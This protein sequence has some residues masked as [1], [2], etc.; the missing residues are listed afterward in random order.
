MKLLKKLIVF[1]AAVGLAGWLITPT[2]SGQNVEPSG[3]LTGFT[4]DGSSVLVTI[5]DASANSSIY[6]IALTIPITA[7][8]QTTNV[9]DL[10]VTNSNHTGGNVNGINIAGITQDNQAVE[11][12][13]N[14]GDTWD[15]DLFGNS[16]LTF[17]VDNSG[18]FIFQ[19]GT[20]T[21]FEI[22][23]GATAG[24]STFTLNMGGNG[25]WV[26]GANLFELEDTVGAMNPT[27]M[28]KFIKNF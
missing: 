10:S 23:T 2:T 6:D 24:N 4:A 19:E 1:V 7:A 8:G 3:G 14:I 22:E 5:T 26:I 25:G 28:Y 15:V 18:N 20:T 27:N 12:A 11:S 13:I 21:M 9:F 17:R 16:G